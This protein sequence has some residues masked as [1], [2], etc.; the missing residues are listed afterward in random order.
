MYLAIGTDDTARRTYCNALTSTAIYGLKCLYISGSTTCSLRTC[1]GLN[2]PF[3]QAACTAYK[4]GCKFISKT[5]P[6]VEKSTTCAYTPAG[7]DNVVK[8]K[9]CEALD[10]GNNPALGCAYV[11]GA[12]RCTLRTCT[13]KTDARSDEDC[14]AWMSTCRWIGGIS[15]FVDANEKCDYIVHP[16]LTGTDVYA[17]CLTL[18]STSHSPCQ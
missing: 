9:R 18:T 10:N 17:R 2:I 13:M 7:A 14:T 8:C 1:A 3:D 4:I 11:E 15:T 5:T 16:S 6:C 12:E